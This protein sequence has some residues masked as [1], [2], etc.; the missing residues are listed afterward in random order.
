MHQHR[1]GH[2]VHEYTVNRVRGI[3]QERT[4]RLA[5]DHPDGGGRGRGIRA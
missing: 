1:Y 3:I 4:D 2:M 5:A